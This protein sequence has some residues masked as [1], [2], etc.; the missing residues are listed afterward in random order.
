MATVVNDLTDNSVDFE[1]DPSGDLPVSGVGKLINV[2][3]SSVLNLT[4][5][6][7]GNGTINSTNDTSD[8]WNEYC[9]SEEDY[10]AYILDH[11]KPKYYEIIF[12]ILY[13]ITFVVGLVGNALVCFAVWRNHNMRTVTN[14]FIVNLAVGDFL[15]ILVCLPPTLILDVIESWFLDTG[16]CKCI[17][18]LQSL[19]LM[20]KLKLPVRSK[21]PA[22]MAAHL[23]LDQLFSSISREE[24]EESIVN[25]EFAPGGN[26]S[27]PFD[28]PASS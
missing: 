16:T 2:A 4:T 18:Y 20:W 28:V 23:D 26:N 12:I 3:I 6:I 7:G 17:L 5:E 22:K 15:V 25:I 10:D 19:T 27:L 14:V 9:W 11:I 24:R 1:A 13:F 8:C 21:T